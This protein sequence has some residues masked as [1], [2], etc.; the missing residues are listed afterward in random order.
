MP[1]LQDPTPTRASRW[2][3]RA[4]RWMKTADGLDISVREWG[5]A[6]G[7]PIVFVHGLAQSHL[8]FLP[9][10]ASTLATRYHKHKFIGALCGPG[11]C[12]LRTG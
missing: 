3:S 11:R 12:A 5:R 7:H 2:P 8:A 6:D 10:L 9:Q 4:Q 1:D